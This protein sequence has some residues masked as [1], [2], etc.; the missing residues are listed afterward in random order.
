MYSIVPDLKKADLSNLIRRSMVPVLIDFWGTGCAP[1]KMLDN[2]INELAQE[3]RG[4]LRVCRVNLTENLDI[5]QE[6]NISSVPTLLIFTRGKMKGK[7]TGLHS[8]SEITK[9]IEAAH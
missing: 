5:A 7:I 1:C 8:K 4:K 6:Y 3:Y 2:V 9:L